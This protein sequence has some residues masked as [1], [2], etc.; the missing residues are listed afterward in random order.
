MSLIIVGS[1]NAINPRYYRS[2]W[3][4]CKV[5]LVPPVLFPG[6]RSRKGVFYSSPS[7]YTKL[8][9]ELW[10]HSFPIATLFCPHTDFS[11]PRIKSRAILQIHRKSHGRFNLGLCVIIEC[12]EI[13]TAFFEPHRESQL[14]IPNLIYGWKLKMSRR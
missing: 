1:R 3:S 13:S 2:C 12:V 4:L 6:S 10:N 14:E 7:L 8:L 9:Y 11:S 5:R